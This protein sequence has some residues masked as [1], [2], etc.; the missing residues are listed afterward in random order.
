MHQ[1]IA[2]WVYTHGIP[3]NAVD[4]DEFIEMVEAIGCFG[5]GFR[6]PSQHDLREKL[7]VEE[8]ARMKSMLQE[9]EEGKKQKWLFSHD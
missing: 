6:P 9:R 2:R 5:P 8:H 1:Y 3:F 7:L 4:N